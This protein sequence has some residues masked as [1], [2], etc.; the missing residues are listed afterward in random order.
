ML[1]RLVVNGMMD[2]AHSKRALAR[3]CLLEK[4][5]NEGTSKSAAKSFCALKL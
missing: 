5:E 4:Q 2:K 1:H 3:K